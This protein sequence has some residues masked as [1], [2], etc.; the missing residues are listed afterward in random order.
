MTIQYNF[1]K[2]VV[3]ND[4]TVVFGR[5]K[6]GKKHRSETAKK[7]QK[8]LFLEL[9]STARCDRAFATIKLF[10]SAFFGE[11]IAFS[12]NLGLTRKSGLG[13]LGAGPRIPWSD[14]CQ[15]SLA[16]N[17]QNDVLRH[18]KRS[19]WGVHQSGRS[20]CG[21]L[22][23]EKMVQFRAKLAVFPPPLLRLVPFFPPGVGDRSRTQNF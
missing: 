1:G 20:R 21:A 22:V 18:K 15:N 13:S 14:S 9:L 17:A 2:K 16:R 23:A 7:C 8:R 19:A 12:P 11:K 10:W 5:R 4:R 3:K 6:R